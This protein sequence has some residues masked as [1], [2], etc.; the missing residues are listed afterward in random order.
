MPHDDGRTLAV[1]Y[2][3]AHI[4]E[5]EDRESGVYVTAEVSHAL[6]KRL[7]AFVS[8]SELRRNGP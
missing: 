1:L 4:L 2:D 6:A 3:Q 5:R 8:G 7:Q